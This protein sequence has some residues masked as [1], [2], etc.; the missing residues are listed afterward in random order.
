MEHAQ[1]KVWGSP[2]YKPAAVAVLYP[3]GATQVLR[4]VNKPRGV[5]SS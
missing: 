3:L 2:R 1:K 5:L 4:D